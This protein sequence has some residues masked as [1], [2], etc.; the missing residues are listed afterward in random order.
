MGAGGRCKTGEEEG[1]HPSQLLP[2]SEQAILALLPPL[3][4]PIPAVAAAEY[5]SFQLTQN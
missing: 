3:A 4:A 5:R 2:V 1:A